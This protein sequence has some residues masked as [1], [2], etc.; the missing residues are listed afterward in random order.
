MRRLFDQHIGKLNAD[1]LGMLL[2][3]RERLGRF[4]HRDARPR[5]KDHHHH[6]LA[7]GECRQIAGRQSRR[8]AEIQ[9]LMGI[10]LTPNDKRRIERRTTLGRR[11]KFR[12]D[13]AQDIVFMTFQRRRDRG[14][15]PVGYD[16][17]RT[18]CGSRARSENRRPRNRHRP[19][20]RTPRPAATAIWD[21]L[22]RLRRP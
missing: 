5:G 13:V 3:R 9:K 6:A 16:G 12:H 14:F 10:G 19:A 1:H 18:C 11:G 22:C 15:D 17:A 2:E 8:Q 4:E 20:H 7:C 21:P